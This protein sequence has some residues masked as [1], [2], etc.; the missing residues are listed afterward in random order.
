MKMKKV[1]GNFP[2]TLKTH[3]YL[4]ILKMSN[5]REFREGQEGGLAVLCIS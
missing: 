1:Y 4:N 2:K 5:Q 3:G